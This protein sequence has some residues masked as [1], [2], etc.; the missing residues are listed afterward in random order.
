M[1]IA[2]GEICALPDGVT[3]AMTRGEAR[4]L[5]TRLPNVTM[6]RLLA[7]ECN[8][9]VL[10]FALLPDINDLLMTIL[11]LSSYKLR[12]FKADGCLKKRTCTFAL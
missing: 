5:R 1:A 8:R 4:L 12:T 7:K 3:C 11:I 10:S 6:V 9:V 2:S